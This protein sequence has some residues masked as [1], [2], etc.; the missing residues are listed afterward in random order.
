M[1]T[2]TAFNYG[3]ENDKTVRMYSPLQLGIKY[4]K[5]YA[6]ASN[7]KGH[8]VHSP[9]VFEFITRV[10]ND[11]R[12]FYAYQPIENLRKL[13]LADT[14]TVAVKDLG[15]GSRVEKTQSRLVKQIA[16]SS[17][18]PARFSQLLFRMVDFYQP[19]IVLEM[20][21]SLGVTTA[22]LAAA[23]NNARII[24]MEGAGEVA[25]LAKKNFEKLQISNAEMLEGNFDDTLPGLLDREKRLDFVFIDGNHRYEPTVRYFHQL[26]PALHE[27][28]ILVFD[29]IHWSKE[30]EQAWND[31]CK[32][33]A[34]NLTIDLFF[35]GLVF[36]RKEN[37]E[38]Q[39]F[40]IRF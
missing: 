4:L 17:L 32:H 27:Y 34:V 11:D 31:I 26:L 2:P 19:R 24:T 10:L 39:H 15:A 7:G 36:F 28:S 23:G 18:K 12:Q 16:H 30:M 5:Y 40:S 3:K 8:G 29:D 20:G 22:Y 37:R 38:K 9:F 14:R 13:L 25:A 1:H 6:T 33:E 35:I 21:T